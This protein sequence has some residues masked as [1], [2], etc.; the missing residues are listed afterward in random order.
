MSFSYL[1]NEVKIEN[2]YSQ[3]E[4]ASEVS[5]VKVFFIQICKMY[6]L[7]TKI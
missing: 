5:H 1:G 2:F 3:D 6:I 7:T 4:A